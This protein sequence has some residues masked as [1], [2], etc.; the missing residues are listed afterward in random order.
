MWMFGDRGPW[1]Y[2]PS[3]DAALG[4]L[5]VFLAGSGGAAGEWRREWEQPMFSPQPADLGPVLTPIAG[6]SLGAYADV[7]RLHDAVLSALNRR[8][9]FE[10]GEPEEELPDWLDAVCRAGGLQVAALRDRPAFG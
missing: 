6:Y 2:G 10:L 3:D 9:A 1:R 5:L 4:S 7:G 8:G